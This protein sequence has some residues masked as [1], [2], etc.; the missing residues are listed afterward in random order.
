MRVIVVTDY[1]FVNGGAGKVALE[2]AAALA[3]LVDHVHV[4]AAVGEVAGTLKDIPNLTVTSLGQKKVTDLPLLQGAI[5]GLWN[6]EA[7]TQFRAL[8]DQ[9]DPKATIVHLHSWRDALT[10]SVFKAASDRG[11]K[12]IVTAHDF[13][14][15]CPLAGFF[16][17][18]NGCICPERG[19]SSGCWRKSCTSGSYIK[20]TWFVGRH[21]IQTSRGGLPDRLKHVVLV[22]EFSEHILAPYLGPDTKR[23]HVPNPITAE[24]GERSTAE[25]NSRFLFVGRFSP[26]KAPIL[27]AKAAYELDLPISFIGTGRLPNEIREA[28]PDAELLGWRSP[29]FVKQMMTQSRAL[30]FPSIWYETQGM[31]V[32]EAASV[33]LPVIV[34]DCTAAMDTIKKYKHGANFKANDVEALKRRLQEFAFPDL[35]RSYSENGFRNF[36]ADPPTIDAHVKRLL[37]VYSEVL[38]D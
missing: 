19:S 15:A 18:R 20:K 34:S 8:L 7:E 32:D 38:A 6:R 30:I 33:G 24:K 37:E 4:F 21:A 35:V 2:S 10:T 12:V 36:W 1:A 14:M 26:E 9:H 28:N 25:S 31:V 23:H 17:E 13:G 27:A 16:D 29:E 5:G 3:P 11:F 22:S